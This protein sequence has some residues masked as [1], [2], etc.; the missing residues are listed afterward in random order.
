MI[1]ENTCL[2]HDQGNTCLICDKENTCLMHD[3]GKYMLNSW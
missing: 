3:E 2:I 1:K